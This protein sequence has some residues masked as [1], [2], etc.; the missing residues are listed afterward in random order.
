MSENVKRLS[1]E[2]DE[3]PN[4]LSYDDL[5]TLLGVLLTRRYLALRLTKIS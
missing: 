3:W 1:F 2:E 4:V 5:K